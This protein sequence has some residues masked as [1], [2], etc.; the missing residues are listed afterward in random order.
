[1]NVDISPSVDIIWN[2]SFE[3]ILHLDIK[4]SPKIQ[5]YFDNVSEQDFTPLFEKSFELSTESLL[6]SND[7]FNDISKW[8]LVECK[9]LRELNCGDDCAI[10]VLL[11]KLDH[12]PHL[13]SIVIGKKSFTLLP[14]TYQKGNRKFY[15]TNC[16][17]LTLIKIGE[18]SFTDCG[19][20]FLKSKHLSQ[21]HI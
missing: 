12:M 2:K 17:K 10:N 15:V 9:G 8:N 19:V 6:I 7:M 11:F 16:P 21:Q 4:R 3:K 1:M 18:Q 5:E 13:E 20:F 14:E